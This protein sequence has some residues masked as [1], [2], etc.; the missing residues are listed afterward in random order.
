M[1]WRNG[2]ERS[3]LQALCC[4]PESRPGPMGPGYLNEWPLGPEEM[5]FAVAVAFAIG[6]AASDD[7]RFYMDDHRFPVRL[8]RVGNP[9]CYLWELANRHTRERYERRLPAQRAN[10]SHSPAHRAGF[11][12]AENHKGLK[13]RQ[14]VRVETVVARTLRYAFAAC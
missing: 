1:E 14:F 3:A 6:V 4:F 8:L 10:R 2:V 9:F 11:R 12:S 13:G 5:T 7:H